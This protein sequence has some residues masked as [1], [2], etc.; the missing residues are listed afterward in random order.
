MLSSPTVSYALPTQKIGAI[1]EEL[2]L[3]ALADIGRQLAVL[4]ET[5]GREWRLGHVQFGDDP[6]A[7]Y[8]VT[9]KGARRGAGFEDD[10][11]GQLAGSERITLVVEVTQ[12]APAQH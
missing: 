3:E 8:R 7:D 5:T 2:R 12:K 1:L 9:A 10:G 6:L 11:D 4:T